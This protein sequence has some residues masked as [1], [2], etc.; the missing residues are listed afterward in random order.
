MEVK[1]PFSLYDF[2][3]YL[4][5]GALAL[6]IIY[7]ICKVNMDPCI[8]VPFD[9]VDRFVD[10]LRD[11]DKKVDLTKVL[12]P[13]LIVSYMFGHLFAYLSSLTIEYFTNRIFG[14]PSKYLLG[15]NGAETP[16]KR[17][18]KN[19]SSQIWIKRSILMIILIVLLPIAIIALFIKLVRDFVTRP[20]D[21]YLKKNIN[22]KVNDLNKELNMEVVLPEESKDYHRLVMHY[23]YLNI[24]T[25]KNKTNNYLALYGYLRSTTLIMVLFTDW[26]FF[27]GAK[28]IWFNHDNDIDWAS[29][30]FFLSCWLISF[31]S[32]MGFVKFYRRFTL[33]NLMTLLTGKWH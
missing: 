32:Y 1:N 4:F 20:L 33:E 31:I 10:F 13:F 21:T 29:W 3:G 23:V 30:I 8:T 14:Y 12:I 9:Y 18:W 15:I 5:P 7:T 25:S 19:D 28:S 26:L 17:Y 6:F 22:E 16:W 11:E 27:V 2:L 24:Q